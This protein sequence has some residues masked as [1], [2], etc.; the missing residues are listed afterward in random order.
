MRGDA[1][2]TAR[3]LLRGDG[4]AGVVIAAGGALAVLAATQPWYHAMAEIAMLGSAQARAVGS[5]R[6]LPATVPGW[7][8][9][10]LGVVA[11]VLGVACALDRP[12]GRAR[13]VL[14]GVALGLAA[15]ALY[16]WLGPVPELAGVAGREGRE[17][18]GL[19]ERLPLGIALELD[20]RPAVGPW[21]VAVAAILV[22][23]G[24][25]AAREL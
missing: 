5:V 7:V 8:A 11:V 12:P 14:V 25:V 23:G 16:G 6:G 3:L 22:A 20:V 19:A 4:V 24:V 17:L 2:L 1:L 13:T 9:L 10:A 15:A 21:L 18:L